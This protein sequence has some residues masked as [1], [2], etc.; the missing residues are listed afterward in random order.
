MLLNA[1]FSAH[2][3]EE[4]NILNSLCLETTPGLGVKA[5]LLLLPL[6][7]NID[8]KIFPVFV[9]P[10][11]DTILESPILEKKKIEIYK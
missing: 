4:R 9:R 1:V 6:N 2:G 3:E 5:F 7:R 11:A 8:A 10:E